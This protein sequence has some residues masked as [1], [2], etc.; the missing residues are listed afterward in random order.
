MPF[1]EYQ[2]TKCGVKA[3]LFVRTINTQATPPKCPDAGRQKGHEMQ[4]IFSPFI[5]HANEMD[6]LVEAEAKFGKEVDA[7]MGPGPDVGKLV[8]RYDK[9]A[10]D[11]PDKA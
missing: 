7:A 8:R 4:R 10:K 5:R 1:Y 9:I 6:K 11:L 2:C 3:E